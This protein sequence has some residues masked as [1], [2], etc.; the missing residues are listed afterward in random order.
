MAGAELKGTKEVNAN[1]AV[2]KVPDMAADDFTGH[3]NLISGC[4]ATG[5]KVPG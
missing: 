5:K 1:T 2:F 3:D 4:S